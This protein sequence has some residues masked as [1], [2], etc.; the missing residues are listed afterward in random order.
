M[1]FEVKLVRS[2]I[3]RKPNQV[4]TANA[5]GLFKVGQVVEVV[6]NDAT[7]GMIKTIFHL[8]EVREIN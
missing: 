5:L 3:A 7:A 6:K 2:L 4:K 8:V 1:K